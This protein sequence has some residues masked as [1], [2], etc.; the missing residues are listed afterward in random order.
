V[1]GMLLI[2][3]L[4]NNK[5]T[6]AGLGPA[7]QSQSFYP[8]VNFQRDIQRAE[9]DETSEDKDCRNDAAN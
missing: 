8:R 1:H 5:N 9:T 6:V 3:Y 4:Y 7:Q 2:E